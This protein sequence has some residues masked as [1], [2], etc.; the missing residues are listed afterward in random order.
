MKNI[1]IISSSPRKGGNSDTLCDEFIR[2][3]VESGNKT[4]K[5]F[6][7]DYN[8][9]YCRGCGVCNGTHKCVQ[10]DDM[11]QLLNKMVNAVAVAM[12]PT[13]PRKTERCSALRTPSVALRKAAVM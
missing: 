10:N 7:K 9:G 12:I 13:H 3:A 4:E 8:I 1:L 2:G 11:A 6:L 5:I